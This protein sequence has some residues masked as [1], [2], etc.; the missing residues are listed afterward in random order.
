[1]NRPFPPAD[2]SAVSRQATP[3][4]PKATKTQRQRQSPS[5]QV[6]RQHASG[7]DILRR[8][9]NQ[10]RGSYQAR[11]GRLMSSKRVQ[12]GDG[13]RGGSFCRETRQQTLRRS[14]KTVVQAEKRSRVSDARHPGEQKPASTPPPLLPLLVHLLVGGGGVKGG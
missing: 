7:L 3:R 4:T 12:F 10:L 5:Q 2:S 13:G 6:N 14:Q 9:K 11:S 8:D 1:M